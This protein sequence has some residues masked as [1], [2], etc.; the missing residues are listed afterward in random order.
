MANQTRQFKVGDLLQKIIAEVMMREVKDPRVKM[1]SVTSVDVSRDLSSA[2]I[3]ISVLGSAEDGEKAIEGLNR[4]KGF[5]R[6]KVGKNS[7]LR[8]TPSLNFKLDRSAEH[9]QHLSN[10]IAEARAKDDLNSDDA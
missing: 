5:I 3:Y 6:H 8:I 7:E 2:K 4:A 1:A 10:L 9:S